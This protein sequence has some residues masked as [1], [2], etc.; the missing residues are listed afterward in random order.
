MAQYVDDL[1]ES[2]RHSQTHHDPT[3]EGLAKE[4]KDAG[5]TAHNKPAQ[6]VT[7]YRPIG[8]AAAAMLMFAGSAWMMPFIFIL[9][10]L[11]RIPP[12]ALG[13]AIAVMT[14]FGVMASMAMFMMKRWSV[15]LF[16]AVTVVSNLLFLA[17]GE[18]QPIHLIVPLVVLA[19]AYSQIKHLR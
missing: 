15:Y 19:V 3:D 2:E 10:G 14:L 8:V 13:A 18:W 4:M 5:L 16:T 11:E 6:E 1:P 9:G 17:V 12:V 7:R